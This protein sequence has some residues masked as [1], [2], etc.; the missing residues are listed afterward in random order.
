MT[1]YY[2]FD[3]PE[4]VQDVFEHDELPSWPLP[5]DAKNLPVQIT[6]PYKKKIIFDC[7]HGTET[8]SEP[9]AFHVRVYSEDLQLDFA[10]GMGKPFALCFSTSGKGK[11]KRYFSGIITHMQSLA[12]FATDASKKKHIA[13]YSFTVRPKLWTMTLSRNTR[14][15]M[16]KKTKEII[17]AVLGEAGVSFQNKASSA[18]KNKREYC[19]QYN[20]S[21]FD[22]IS[23]LMEEEGIFYY[24]EYAAGGEKMVLIDKNKSAAV[25]SPDVSIDTSKP[26]TFGDVTLFN[27]QAQ[28]TA[29]EFSIRDYDYMKPDTVLKAKEKGKGKGGAVYEYPGVYKEAGDGA[30]IAK[31]RLEATRW[32]HALVSGRGSVVTFAAGSSFKLAKHPRSSINTKYL[33]YRV[34]HRLQHRLRKEQL[35][36]DQLPV[37]YS[38]QFTALPLAVP[39]MPL[40]RTPRPQIIGNQTAVVVGPS[41][42]EIHIDKEGR[43]LIQFPWD[44]EGAKDGKTSIFVRHMQGWAGESFGMV[45]IPRIGME[46][47]VSFIDGNPDE[48]LIIGCVYNGKNKMPAEVTGE[49][50][51]TLLKTKTSPKDPPKANLMSFDDTK[52]AEK[53]TFNATK[54]LEISSIADKNLFLLKQAGKETMTSTEITEGMLT[55]LITKGDKT[56][57]LTEGNMTTELTKGDESTTLTEG[58][59][60]TLLTKGNK[61]TTLTEGALS[62]VVTKGEKTTTIDEGNYTIKL[63]KGSLQITLDDGDE[64][65]TLTK[66]NYVL[67]V[68]DGTLTM[69]AAKDI[70]I[71]SDAGITMQAAKDIELKADG[72]VKITAGKNLTEKAT[73]DVKRSGMK[74]QDEAQ[75]DYACKALNVK[76][77]ASVQ[78]AF[79]GTA[80]T[81]EGKATV[82]VKGGATAALK[83][84]MTMLG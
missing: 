40:R 3:H 45:A 71:K 57:T 21:N 6:S 51:I 61:S 60:T 13:Y 1:H 48:P 34:E 54:D 18:G 15:F 37:L 32:P 26:D 14:I 83:G 53:I 68:A 75:T 11:T 7:M 79:S 8:I 46:V 10:K 81:V 17:E 78:A 20:E 27:T 36:E 4:D 29:K 73:Q 64:V 65:V 42:K 69:Q 58:N 50:R 56:I 80:V 55:T 19:V 12:A 28:M 72:E 76:T 16:K 49:P 77:E 38:N 66:G 2:R 31:R 39:F 84:A 41:D 33:L 74:I 23:R 52:D 24:F 22:F 9:F 63:T 67:K 44:T 5:T 70:L 47:V 43:V 25:L 62:T 30:K 59:M 35:E 82:E